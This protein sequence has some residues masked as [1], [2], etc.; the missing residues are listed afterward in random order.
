MIFMIFDVVEKK[1]QWSRRIFT[2]HFAD[3]PKGVVVV[4][5]VCPWTVSVIYYV[6]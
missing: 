6:I 1:A 4:T 2:I 3:L 5:Y